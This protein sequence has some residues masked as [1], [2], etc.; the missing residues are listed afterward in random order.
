MT[1]REAA[2]AALI[3]IFAVMALYVIAYLFVSWPGH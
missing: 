1:I 3:L 2:A